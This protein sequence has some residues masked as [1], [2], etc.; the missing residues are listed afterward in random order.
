M[1]KQDLSNFIHEEI[2]PILEELLRLRIDQKIEQEE[3][4]PSDLLPIEAQKAK[5]REELLKMLN[6]EDKE[7]AFANGLEVF[8]RLYPTV[9]DMDEQKRFE[10]EMSE[11]QKRIIATMATIP[12]SDDSIAKL[13]GI[14]PFMLACMWRVANVA[15]TNNNLE[16]ALAIYDTILNIDENLDAVWVT[17]A[18]CLLNAG[19]IDEAI[20]A[21][22]NAKS[23]NGE[24]PKPLFGL[25]QSASMQNHEHEA[26]N[27]LDVLKELL[28]RTGKMEEYQE[29]LAL[30]SDHINKQFE[31]EVL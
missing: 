20:A 22:N 28:T 3:F 31:K 7:K 1:N 6:I 14:S 12:S 15:F 4:I 16:E 24:N 5:R 30:L 11:V 9:L 10:E 17:Y 23:L 8:E 25:I 21:Y 26:F 29:M 13:Y 18:D 19:R 27:N 2:N